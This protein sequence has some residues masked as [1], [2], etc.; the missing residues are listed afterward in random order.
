[1][2]NDKYFKEGNQ[3]YLRSKY[4]NYF[5]YDSKNSFKPSTTLKPDSRCIFKVKSF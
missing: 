5:Y 1:M 4:G 2:E 3:I